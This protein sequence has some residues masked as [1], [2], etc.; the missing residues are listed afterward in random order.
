LGRIL[1][2]ER[3][4]I[5]P[6]RGGSKRLPRKNVLPVLGR[7]MIEYPI[8]AALRSDLF[9]EVIVSTEDKEI[10]GVA[11]SAGARVMDRPMELATDKSTV[12]EVCLYVLDELEKIGKKP[13]KFCCIYATAIFLRP[14]D[15]IES[16]NLLMKDP[17]CEAVMGVSE[18]NLHPVQALVEKHGFLEWMWPEYED[19]KSQL[20][21]HL[22]CSSGSIYWNVTDTFKE[23]K[24]FYVKRLKGYEIPRGRAVDIDTEE[25]YR[26][27]KALASYLLGG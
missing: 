11:E 24:T 22:V 26:V 20:Y 19:L 3:L 14:Q 18:Y 10:A 2:M 21:P 12:T 17:P 16:Y 15:L 7:P 27:A 13:K 1:R 25:D 8:T 6:A 23:K 5:I 4:A 9:D